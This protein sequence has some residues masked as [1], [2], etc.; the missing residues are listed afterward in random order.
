MSSD[1]AI[2][3]KSFFLHLVASLSGI[4]S[5]IWLRSIGGLRPVS[6][7]YYTIW[8]LF[9]QIISSCIFIVSNLP[10]VLEVSPSK[11]YNLIILFSNFS[12]LKSLLAKKEEDN[13]TIQQNGP[14]TSKKKDLESSLSN[15]S[16]YK[17]LLFHASFVMT[18]GTTLMFWVI[19]LVDPTALVGKDFFYPELM[20]HMHHTFP[21]IFSVIH[22]FI[23]ADKE[24]NTF[25]LRIELV[26]ANELGMPF[27]FLINTLY[28]CTII[29]TSIV[30]KKW[31]YPFMNNLTTLQLGILLVGL[32][33]VGL[34]IS[35]IA[36]QVL[37]VVAKLLRKKNASKKIK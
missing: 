21:F 11:S 12:D 35:N 36:N 14:K 18:L 5:L 26:H 1:N 16:V 27:V 23:F 4:S 6:A 13:P 24:L 10:S 3:I 31:P 8:T 2:T 19:H 22:M 37:F 28:M 17:F 33:V 32:N 9:G 7:C 15:S 25:K 20:N 29:F 34:V 30:R